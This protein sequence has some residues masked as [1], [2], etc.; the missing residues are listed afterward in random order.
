MSRPDL[1]LLHFFVALLAHALGDDETCN[2]ESV[3]SILRGVDSQLALTRLEQIKGGITNKLWKVSLLRQPSDGAAAAGAAST[4]LTAL[5]R[6]YGENTDLL[7]DRR[8]ETEVLVSLSSLGFEVALIGAFQNGRVES[9]ING[10]ALSTAE[11]RSP[12]ISHAIAR[13]LARLH[14]K[15]PQLSSFPDAT[16]AHP[17]LLPTLRKWLQ[18]AIAAVDDMKR[19]IS[20]VPL[21]TA[22][23]KLLAELPVESIVAGVRALILEIETI[24]VM[25]AEHSRSHSRFDVVF[26]HNDLLASN[27]ILHDDGEV[28]A[29]AEGA[30]AAHSSPTVHLIDFEYSSFTVSHNSA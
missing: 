24:V 14:S 19:G 22:Q 13:Q 30:A 5:V 29:D 11:M 2:G 21:T 16:A 28:A 27:I 1:L 4:P 26:G 12:R 10:H 25:P 7:I 20:A 18:L 23:V 17:S 6:C 8:K 3:A 9:W 15:Q